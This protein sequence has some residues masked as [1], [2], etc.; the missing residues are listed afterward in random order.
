[1]PNMQ[2]LVGRIQP[3]S[4]GFDNG[5]H[6]YAV[7]RNRPAKGGP[8]FDLQ[9]YSHLVNP[10]YYLWTKQPLVPALALVPRIFLRFEKI[11]INTYKVGGSFFIERRRP[12]QGIAIGLSSI[13]Q[14][15]SGI[16]GG[17]SSS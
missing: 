10:T 5:T 11:D 6:W 4:G 2:S 9:Y 7:C 15:H 12:G 17:Q 16:T 13:A 1:M 3:A 14:G 8:G